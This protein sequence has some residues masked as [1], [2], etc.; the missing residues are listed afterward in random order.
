MTRKEAAVRARPCRRSTQSPRAR[1][2]RRMGQGSARWR[3]TGD[4]A[5]K[6]V[7]MPPRGEGGAAVIDT[8][9]RHARLRRGRVSRESGMT[10]RIAVVGAGLAGLVA[11]SRLTAAG[12]A[13]TVF[14]KSR[15]L[16]GRLATRRSEHGSFDHGAP[17]VHCEAWQVAPLEARAA[18]IRWGE[19]GHVGLPGMSGLVRPLA[20]GLDIRTGTE[21]TGLAA[22]RTACGSGSP[23]GGGHDH[24]LG[25]RRHRRARASAGGAGGALRRDR[26]ARAG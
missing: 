24:H 7:A 6:V 25:L 13:V 23:R 2:G 4:H 20:E 14:E 16:G 1:P 15:G 8:T 19:A 12:C 10:E 26:R 21:V 17:V 11:A 3:E 22:A 5:A 18:C 9:L